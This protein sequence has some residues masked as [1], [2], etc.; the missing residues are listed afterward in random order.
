M[1][2]GIAMSCVVV[3]R[4]IVGVQGSSGEGDVHRLAADVDH[5]LGFSHLE[6]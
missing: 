6:P 5:A 1:D 4:P 2:V 3:S